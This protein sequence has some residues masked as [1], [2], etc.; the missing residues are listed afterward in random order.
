[1]SPWWLVL[2]FFAGVVVCDG[3]AGYGARGL[4]A[5]AAHGCALWPEVEVS[6]REPQA[7]S[8]HPGLASAVSATVPPPSRP[9][10]TLYGPMKVW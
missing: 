1:M 2:A 8:G 3:Y 10:F 5:V 6:G 4:W 7:E 9:G